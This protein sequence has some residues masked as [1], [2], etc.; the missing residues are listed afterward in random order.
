MYYGRYA[1]GK[2]LPLCKPRASQFLKNFGQISIFVGSLDGQMPHQLALQKA[3]P[4]SH[5]SSHLI[6]SQA[7]FQVD[8][9][10]IH[11]YKFIV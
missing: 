3:S 2:F 4:T 11:G 7:H 1:N 6:S 9:F 5:A 10:T 8:F